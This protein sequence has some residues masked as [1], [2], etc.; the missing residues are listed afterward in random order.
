[1]KLR[2]AVIGHPVKHSKSP[3]IHQYWMQQNGIE[4]TY[5]TIDIKPENLESDIQRLA[6]QGLNGFNVT[7][8]HKE[9]LLA[10]CDELDET[11]R[12]IGAVNTVKI[13]DGR[14]YGYNTDA[15]G[16]IENLR[17]SQP[18]YDFENGSAV[19]LGAGGAA[20]AAIYGL[21]QAGLENITLTNRTQER[22][23]ALAEEFG[24][25]VAAWKDRDRILKNKTL[26]VNTTTLGMSGKDVLKM[27]LYD[28][29]VHAVVYDIVYAPLL[30]DLLL[31]A[32]DNGFHAVTGIGM[33]LH[34]A[35]PAF[36]LWTGILPDVTDEL[37]KLVLT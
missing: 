35:R 22:A 32:Q 17:Q 4:G 33:L 6:D 9:A 15:Y 1:M 37:E 28:L 30:T 21:Q 11:A 27:D 2:A 3:R 12:A 16:F 19:I 5:G 31:S 26:L 8:P 24:C 25:E 14:L 7:V 10:L 36:E 34:Q 20:R 29:P 18:D 23:E 13:E